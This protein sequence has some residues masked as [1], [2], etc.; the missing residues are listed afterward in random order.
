MNHYKQNRFQTT[1]SKKQIQERNIMA[2]FFSSK[3]WPIIFF[4]LL[5]LDI[6]VFASRPPAS[7]TGKDRKKGYPVLCTTWVWIHS[8]VTSYLSTIQLQ[9][10]TSTNANQTIF[11]YC[12]CQ[13]RVP[14]LGSWHGVCWI[15]DK[16]R[17]NG[18]SDLNRLHNTS[19]RSFSFSPFFP[20][21]GSGRPPPLLPAH[22]AAD[23]GR[24]ADHLHWR[25]GWIMSAM[26]GG[27]ESC[28]LCTSYSTEQVI[29][30]LLKFRNLILSAKPPCVAS[31]HN[32]ACGEYQGEKRTGVQQQSTTSNKNWVNGDHPIL[33]SEKKKDCWNSWIISE[34]RSC[35][36]T[37]EMWHLT[38]FVE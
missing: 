9:T 1:S 36:S 17:G 3:I 33:N 8:P 22:G 15:V 37:Q 25:R 32:H 7:C 13:V 14:S 19:E 28:Q 6:Q 21:P 11:K 18:P 16:I 27:P 2:R 26:F 5:C 29:D 20:L 34:A 35:Y 30:Y 4:V 38:V 24:G 12:T 23:L 10:M 31:S